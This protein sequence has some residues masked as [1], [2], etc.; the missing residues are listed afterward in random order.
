VRL[1]KISYDHAAARLPATVT[2]TEDARRTAVTLSMAF[3][4]AELG[5]RI[6]EDHGTI[7]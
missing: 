3:P 6:V 1:R 4:G 7:E 2:F 5:D